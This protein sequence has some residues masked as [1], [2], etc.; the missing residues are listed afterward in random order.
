MRQNYDLLRRH[1][2]TVEEY[3]SMFTAQSG[4]CAICRTESSPR[5]LFVDHDHRSGRVRGLLCSTC[6]TGLG[7]FSDDAGLLEDAMYYLR[8]HVDKQLPAVEN[9]AILPVSPR[10]LGSA[11]GY[12]GPF[13]LPPGTVRE[14][15]D[16]R[17]AGF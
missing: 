14:V 9:M 3:E 12:A 4:A 6:N 11:D 17:P 16:V 15:A 1:G 7:M 8:R 5:G 2:I 13:P 10:D